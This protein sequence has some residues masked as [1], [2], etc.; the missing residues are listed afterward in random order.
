MTRSVRTLALLGGL[1]AHAVAG[2]AAPTLDAAALVVLEPDASVE[3]DVV[4]ERIAG[5]HRLLTDPALREAL[6]RAP[7]PAALPLKMRSA[8][9]RARRALR[10]FE[11]A[12][13][14]TMLDEAHA[15]AQDLPP[16][17]DGID[18]WCDLMRGEFELAHT[19]RDEV[20]ERHA[21]RLFIAVHPSAQPDSRRDSPLFVRRIADARAERTIAPSFVV[22]LIVEPAGAELFVDGALAGRAPLAMELAQGLHIVW[23]R[24]PGFAPRVSKFDARPGRQFDLSLKALDR[25][26]RA[27]QLAE[28]LRQKEGEERVVVAHALMA[29][30]DV[31]TL[32]VVGRD[33]QVEE[34]RAA[35]AETVRQTDPSRSAPPVRRVQPAEPARPWYRR[36]WVWSVVGVGGGVLI[37][38]ALAGAFAPSSTVY[39]EKVRVS[40]CR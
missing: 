9:D 34:L 24:A 13:T 3:L 5:R 37:V 12:A 36:G 29:L 31:V 18:A 22:S 19:A 27:H 10:H 2:A 1:M 17:N 39:D 6:E 14:R 38:G 8:L 28:E 35:S 32:L 20:A 40:C 15:V 26:A 25:P 16:E 7:R 23:A 30:L 4:R 21:A 33:G 11:L